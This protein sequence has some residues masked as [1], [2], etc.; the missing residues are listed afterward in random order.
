MTNYRGF[1]GG[2][3]GYAGNAILSGNEVDGEISGNKSGTGNG[4]IVSWAVGTSLK[5]CVFKGSLKTV[6]NIGGL[7]YL[8]DSGSSIDACKVLGA[9][10]T[11][12]TDTAATDAAVLVSNAAE[13][14]VIKDCGIKGTLDG[15]AITLESNLI[16]TDGGA[17]V[18]G[19]Y[20]I[21]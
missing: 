13:G 11:K 15:E 12:G 20:L 5:D 2:V 19:T 18:T 1:A 10:I 16:T 9:T 6:R 8:L 7:V 21:E 17:T 14:T 4:G 3:A